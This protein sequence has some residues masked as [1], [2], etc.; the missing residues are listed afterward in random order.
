MDQQ[1]PLNAQPEV[2]RC[3]NKPL[4]VLG[5]VVVVVVGTHP[6]AINTA[7]SAPEP[8]LLRQNKK[9]FL[10][11]PSLANCEEQKLETI[12]GK[13]H[14]LRPLPCGVKFKAI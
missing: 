11:K 7:T 1:T 14:R 9:H 2:F 10:G 5:V 8:T 6:H 3:T 4:V 12:F 13:L